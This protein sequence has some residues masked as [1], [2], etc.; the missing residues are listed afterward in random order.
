[1]ASL[2]AGNG[3]Q[4]TYGKHACY[5]ARGWPSGA[6]GE[7]QR[8]GPPTD[9]CADGRLVRSVPRTASRPTVQCIG[10]QVL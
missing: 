2:L 5:G 6:A 4:R 3:C 10:A 9:A 8:K 1:M 7:L